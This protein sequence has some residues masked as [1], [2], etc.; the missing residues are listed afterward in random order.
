MSWWCFPFEQLIGILQKTHTNNHVG[1]D[2]EKT[3]L[4]SFLRGAN[5]H[6][7]LNRPNCPQLIQQFKILFDKALPPKNQQETMFAADP[8]SV[9]QLLHA[10]YTYHRV[11]FSCQSTHLRGSLIAYYLTTKPQDLMVGSI[12]EIK[13]KSGQVLFAIKH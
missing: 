6:R 2:L 8:P 5:L 9:R 3:I 7:H 4:Q 12:Q 1:G 13:T 11:T 10:Y